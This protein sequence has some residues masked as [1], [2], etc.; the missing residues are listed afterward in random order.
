MTQAVY[1]TGVF[2][3]GF[4]LLLND[5]EIIFRKEKII[6]K[7]PTTQSSYLHSTSE[8]CEQLHSMLAGFSFT[9]SLG[10]YFFSIEF[11]I[12]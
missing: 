2:L 8:L 4:A 1:H 9:L 7:K 5:I 12:V 10:V 6:K 3:N 11:T